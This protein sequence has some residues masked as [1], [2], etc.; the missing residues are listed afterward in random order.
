MRRMLDPKEV[1]GGGGGKLYCHCI[2]LTDGT[3]NAIVVNLFNYS[4]LPFTI[5]SFK[6][7]LGNKELPCS[8]IIQSF[9][10]STINVIPFFLCV[11]KGNLSCKG[12]SMQYG[13]RY[14]DIS[15]FVFKDDVM[16]A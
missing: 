16:P 3:T 12:T 10:G 8:G 1:G 5:D 9:K 15:T 13:F 7:K 6:E 2:K 14:L 4:E 11:S